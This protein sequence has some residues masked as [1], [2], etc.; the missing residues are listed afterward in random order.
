MH[1]KEF[2]FFFLR[3]SRPSEVLPLKMFLNISQNECLANAYVM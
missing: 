3:N 2:F 1:L